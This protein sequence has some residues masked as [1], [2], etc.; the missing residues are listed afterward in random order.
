MVESGSRLHGDLCAI[1]AARTLAASVCSLLPGEANSLLGISKA[2]PHQ[3]RERSFDWPSKEAVLPE[4]L[5]PL[6]KNIAKNFVETFY[7]EE[8]VTL[9]HREGLWLKEQ[10]LRPC[11]CR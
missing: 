10:V 5:S 11:L 2:Q 6:P 4:R 9:M 7:K 3:L 8:G 1:V